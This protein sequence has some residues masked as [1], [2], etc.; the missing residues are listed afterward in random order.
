M[1]AFRVV[2]FPPLLDEDLGLAEAVEDLA[3]EQFVPEPGV[4]ALAVSVLPWAAR[5]DLGRPGTDGGNPVPDRLRDELGAVVGSDVGGWS[6]QDEQIGESI[7]DVDRT[8]LPPD[9]DRQALPAELVQDVQRAECLPVISVA[10]DEIIA[11]D[12]VAMLRPQAQA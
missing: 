8:Q 4:E 2:V 7:D 12:M 1:G 9:P 6:A 5:F 11:P 10:M 3:V